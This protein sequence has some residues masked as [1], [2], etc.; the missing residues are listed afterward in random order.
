MK[1]FQQLAAG[2][3]VTPLMNAIQRQPELWNANPIRTKHPGTAHAEV[4]DILLRFNDVEEFLR[5][6]DP[7]TITDD[8]EAIP[9]DAWH[10]LP[11]ARPIIF[12]LMR[13]VEATRLGRVIITKL[14][15]GRQITPHVDGGAPATYFERFQ[16]AP[17]VAARRALPHRRR[18]REFSHWRRVAHQQRCRAQCRQQFGRRPDRH[19][20]RCE[21]HL[22]LTAQVEPLNAKTLDEIMRL[23]PGHYD[24]LSEHKI[25]GIPLDPQ[26]ALYLARA[27]AGQVLYVTLRGSRSSDRLSRL[28]RR[29]R[30]A[31]PEL[32]DGDRR[33]LLRLA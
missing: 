6:G 10:K 18:D 11:Q 12:D 19:D 21:V 25:M 24:G 30:H 13:T 17:A 15:P 14:P 16:V 2:I 32:P 7:T 8:H 31:L 29:A 22:M 33:Y 3:N 4:S 20:H 23:L 9:G 27:E 26:Y 1:Y 5:T 28:L